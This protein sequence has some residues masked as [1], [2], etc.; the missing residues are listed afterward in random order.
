MN[1]LL[2]LILALYT[3][4]K[5]LHSAGSRNGPSASDEIFEHALEEGYE[6]LRGEPNA[7]DTRMLLQ[8]LHHMEPEI[9]KDF[10]LSADR[11]A[12]LQ[13]EMKVSRWPQI[14]NHSRNEQES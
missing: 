11:K 6:L 12:E 2:V 3:G 5:V 8:Q 7:D 1:I 10:T 14:T 13:E 4:A 9:E